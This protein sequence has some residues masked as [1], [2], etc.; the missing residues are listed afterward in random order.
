MKALVCD[1]SF[2]AVSALVAIV[3]DWSEAGDGAWSLAIVE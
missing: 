2:M 1:E 3:Y